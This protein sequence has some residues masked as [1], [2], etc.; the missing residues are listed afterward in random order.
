MLNA[1]FTT[2]SAIIEPEFLPI[3]VLRCGNKQFFA[4]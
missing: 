1:N 2:L 4:F 3:E